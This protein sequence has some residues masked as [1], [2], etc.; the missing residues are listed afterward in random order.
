LLDEI[1]IALFHHPDG[2]PS[3]N[4]SRHIKARDANI[5]SPRHMPIPP[6]VASR[7]ALTRK[8][9]PMIED[10][11]VTVAFQ[12]EETVNLLERAR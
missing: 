8:P 1:A 2:M 3:R 11:G 9:L 10:S 5:P 4:T 6:I 12:F 7:G